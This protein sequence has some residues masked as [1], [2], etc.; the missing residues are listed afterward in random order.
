V[1]VTVAATDAASATAVATVRSLVV[2]PRSVLEHFPFVFSVE[3]RKSGSE[4]E[5]E[6]VIA[7]QRHG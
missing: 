5:A 6:K 4:R 2:L 7:A 3:L 1:V